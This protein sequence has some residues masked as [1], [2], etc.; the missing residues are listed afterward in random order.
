M[1]DPL[2]LPPGRGFN[3]LLE[4]TPTWCRIDLHLWT[5]PGPCAD[6]GLFCFS[7]RGKEV[8][9]SLSPSLLLVLPCS[10]LCVKEACVGGL[11]SS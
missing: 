7:M 4:I 9:S 2:L 8:E 3:L 5:D 1:A 6:S 11:E 10:V